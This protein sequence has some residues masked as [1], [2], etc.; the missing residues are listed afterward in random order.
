LDFYGTTPKTL[1]MQPHNYGILPKQRTFMS[2]RYQPKDRTPP[3]E[4]LRET[5]AAKG[6]TAADLAEKAGLPLDEVHQ[7]LTSKI[8]ITSDAAAKLETALG[9]P[10]VF[11]RTLDAHYRAV[12]SPNAN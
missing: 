8:S 12:V 11:W 2:F 3:G 10:A 9:T 5:M 1:W 7:L 4:T 6:L